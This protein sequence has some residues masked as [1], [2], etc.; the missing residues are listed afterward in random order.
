MIQIVYASGRIRG[1]ARAF[2][3]L[4]LFLAMGMFASCHPPQNKKNQTVQATQLSKEDSL[5]GAQFPLDEYFQ[6][7]RD[8]LY[9]FSKPAKG[10]VAPDGKAFEGK[11]SSGTIVLILDEI[12]GE[13]NNFYG[14][15]E[16]PNP[17]KPLEFII[18]GIRTEQLDKLV[19]G[20][21]YRVYWM[22]TV[23]NTEPFDDDRY[24]EFLTYR[25]DE[26]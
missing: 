13:P 3:Y 24:R 21:K 2:G 19:P 9:Q 18:Y 11:F 16:E 14:H 4:L 10:I 23:V 5:L 25:I 17:Q 6:A 7:Q 1:H 20:Q 8:L 22:E 12:D 26:L 15:L